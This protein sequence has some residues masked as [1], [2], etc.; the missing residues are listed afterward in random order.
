MTDYSGGGDLQSMSIDDFAIRYPLF[1][2][3]RKS[4]YVAYD[5]GSIRLAPE[6]FGVPIFTTEANVVKY[7]THTKI[8]AQIK[9]LDQASV[10]RLFLR[11]LRDPRTTTL[12]FDLLPDQQGNLRTDQVYPIAAVLERIV[13]EGAFIWGYPVYVLKHQ[14]D[15]LCVQGD[16]DGVQ[17]KML[18]VFTDAD[19]AERAI[20]PAPAPTV[21][22]PVPNRK[23]F[24]HLV[25]S[26]APDVEG[27][28]FDLPDPRHRPSTRSAVLRQELLAHLEFEC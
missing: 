27:A 8:R 17:R 10:F 21:A 5:L 18:V 1:A 9:Q 24:A 26:L 2:L 14:N 15:Y 20:P 19:L 12:L 3:K 23:E 28:V 22:A 25:R 6:G 13:S 11:S 16:V 4:G 7:L